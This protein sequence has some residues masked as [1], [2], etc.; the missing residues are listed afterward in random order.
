MDYLD[1]KKRFR[2]QIILM[3]G[4]VLVGIAII[5]GTLILVYQAYGF[6]V[7]RDGTVIQNGLFFFSSH[8]H[9]ADI[10]VNGSKKSVQTNTRLGLPAGKYDITLKR[11]GYHD[12]Q[13]NISLEG[14]SVQHVDYPF[15]I[16]KTLVTKKIQAYASAPGLATQSPDQRWLLVQ[17]TGSMTAFDVYDLKNPAKPAETLTLPD[18]LLSKP[19]ASESWQLGEWAGDN[20]HGVLQHT[21]G[22]KKEFIVVDRNDAAKAVN[23]N[24]TLGISPAKLTLKDK[25]YDSYYVYD[26][27]NLQ[28]AS[29]KT[30]GAQPYLEHVLNYQPYGDDTVLY[31]T[32]SKV[33]PG[34]TQIRLRSGD[35]T[36]VIRTFPA[37]TTY[38]LDLTKYSGDMY[39]VAGA[40]SENKVYIYKDPS[41][42]LSANP[43]H[44]LV[45]SQILHVNAPNYVSFSDSAQFI[46]AEN[47]TEYGVY[48]IENELAYHYVSPFALDPP[49]AHA[50]WMDG[51]RLT[52]V[53]GGK[54]VIFDY[55]N[56]NQHVLAGAGS[57][58]LP[59][60]GPD[61][62]FVY[63]MTP[64]PSGQFDLDQT[65]LLTP[66]DQ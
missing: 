21:Y 13:R 5:I 27:S 31:A 66:A 44:A 46:V 45:P 49:Q 32:D 54:L 59:A 36:S 61:Y 55:D 4:Y 51:N 3:V 35:K 58:Y 63:T 26:G 33:P 18:G 57:Q 17:K 38:L 50:S 19:A 11:G 62:K 22:D 25:K 12:W 23:I 56:T 30:P 48:D 14:G 42:Q 40:S 16:P 37:G 64:Q 60:F 1:P 20:A 29:L 65:A 15:L 52:Y 7:N 2:H 53:S 9:P 8:P 39:V 24:T 28:T 10:Y 43:N 6:G 47:G 34:K 41:G